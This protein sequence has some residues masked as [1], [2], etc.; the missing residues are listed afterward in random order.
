MTGATQG[1][2]DRLLQYTQLAGLERP[3]RE[4]LNLA[5]ALFGSRLDPRFVMSGKGCF[6]WSRYDLRF[7]LP[8]LGR[9]DEVLAYVV[10]TF[11]SAL[12]RT[13]RGRLKR[14]DLLSPKWYRY[15]LRC[16]VLSFRKPTVQY[17]KLIEKQ[18]Q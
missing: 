16:T 6:S 2:W 13:E 10:G 3:F 14:R 5:K 12:S 9:I 4:R 1:D 15:H 7:R 18:P 11:R 17:D 8:R